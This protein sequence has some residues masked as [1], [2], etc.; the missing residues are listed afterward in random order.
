MPIGPSDQ[1]HAAA[2]KNPAKLVV[3]VQKGGP[4]GGDIVYQLEKP[5]NDNGQYLRVQAETTPSRASTTQFGPGTSISDVTDRFSDGL[6]PGIAGP[7]NSVQTFYMVPVG[8][9]GKPN[10]LP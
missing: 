9:D 1:N 2:D 4:K 6:Q 3:D 8:Q 10:G 7:G 5:K